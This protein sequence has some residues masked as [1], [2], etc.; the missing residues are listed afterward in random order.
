MFTLIATIAIALSCN[1]KPTAPQD[2][3]MPMYP[4]ASVTRELTSDG[5]KSQEMFL[6]SADDSPRIIAHY[7]EVLERDGWRVLRKD[8]GIMSMLAAEK[9][10]LLFGVQVMESKGRRMIHQTLKRQKAWF[11]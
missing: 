2:M 1:R 11:R 9:G 4:A 3:R 6:D 8:L 7:R 5:G 10:D